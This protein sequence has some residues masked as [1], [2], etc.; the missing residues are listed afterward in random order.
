VAGPAIKQLVDA[1]PATSD[2]EV[3]AA[4]RGTGT[5]HLEPSP[6]SDLTALAPRAYRGAYFLESSYA[7]G[8]GR[9]EL[10]YLADRPDRPDRPAKP[11]RSPR[12]GGR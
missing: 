2:E 4:F 6:L 1:G 12:R 3:H 8:F 9:I 10:D 7:E 11:R 5:V